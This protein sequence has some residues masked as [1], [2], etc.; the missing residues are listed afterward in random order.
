MNN[1]RGP[2]IYRHYKGGLYDIFGLALWEP[3]AGKKDGDTGL[4]DKLVDFANDFAAC[5]WDMVP[6]ESI[7]EDRQM[8]LRAAKLLSEQYFVIYEPMTPGSMLEDLPGVKFWARGKQ[9]F[10]SDVGVPDAK[11]IDMTQGRFIF[12]TGPKDPELDDKLVLTRALATAAKIL[13]EVGQ[14]Q[15]AR[16]AQTVV[17]MHGATR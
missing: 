16:S 7:E 4:A 9:D 12:K 11:G 2:G 15:A 17:S 3:M 1:Y 14:P 6:V 10:D 13:E 8:L 5:D